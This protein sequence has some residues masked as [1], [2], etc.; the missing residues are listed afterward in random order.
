MRFC[1][2]YYPLILV[3][4]AVACRSKEQKLQ[5]HRLREFVDVQAIKS[6]GAHNYS[7]HHWLTTAELQDFKKRFGAMHYLPGGSAQVKS[8]NMGSSIFVLHIGK[9]TYPIIESPTDQYLGVPNKLVSQN[10]NRLAEEDQNEPILLLFKF[11]RPA[12]LNNYRKGPGI[13]NRP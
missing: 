5:E 9:S 12:N 6:V 13:P 1:L 3:I 7:G 4:L 10:R 8:V 2:N 11:A